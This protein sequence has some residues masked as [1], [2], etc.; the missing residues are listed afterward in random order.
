MCYQNV[1]PPGL[2][3]AKPYDDAVGIQC[4]VEK[5]NISSLRDLS[6]QGTSSTNILSLRDIKIDNKIYS[7][8]ADDLFN[9]TENCIY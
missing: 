6:A 2:D 4:L 5:M 9:E 3:Y 8:T 1:V 7:F